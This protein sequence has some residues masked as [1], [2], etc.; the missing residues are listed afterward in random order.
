MNKKYIVN[1]VTFI[2]AFCI[3][4][5]FAKNQLHVFPANLY[6]HE[7][8]KDLYHSCMGIK[9]DTKDSD[10]EKTLE[11]LPKSKIRNIIELMGTRI[12]D[13]DILMLINDEEIILAMCTM[14][15]YH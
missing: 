4:N 3:N 6:T 14:Q 1:I 8:L 7:E 9:M 5:I 2:L 15:T 10:V 12:P 13:D 11:I